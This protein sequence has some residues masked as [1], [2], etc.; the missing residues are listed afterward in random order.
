MRETSGAE[1][2]ENPLRQAIVAFGVKNLPVAD[3]SEEDLPGVEW[4]GSPLHL[5]N[6]RAALRRVPIGQVEY[7]CLRAPNGEIVSKC[8][9]NYA[10]LPGTGMLYQLAT[11]DDVMGL[12]IGTRLIRAAE[13]R[14]RKRG[15]TKASL[16]V[17]LDNARAR[18]LYERLGFR[19]LREVTS[20][21]DQQAPDGSIRRHVAHQVEMEKEL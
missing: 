16:R 4:S 5:Q 21:W 13:D 7:L 17:D 9:I 3:L 6:I 14:I 8:G 10:W 12:G 20:E 1:R 11:R 2:D 15:L 18:A 19:P